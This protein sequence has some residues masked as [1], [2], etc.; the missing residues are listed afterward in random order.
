MRRLEFQSAGRIREPWNVSPSPWVEMRRLEFQSAG[1]IREPWNP[2]PPIVLAL[3]TVG[4]NPPG[5]SGSLGTNTGPVV[6][7]AKGLVSIRR[8]DQGALEHDKW[9]ESKYEEGVSI[10]RADQG[11]LELAYCTKCPL[12]YRFQSAGRIREPWNDL[13]RRRRVSHVR[14]SIR[15]ADQGALEP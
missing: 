5:G 4:F 7:P 10:R 9:R 8:A 12:E 11:A 6:I 2:Y 14:V 13:H 15:R 3:D 1:R